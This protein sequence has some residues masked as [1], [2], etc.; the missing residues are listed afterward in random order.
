MFVS[1]VVAD[2]AAQRVAGLRLHAAVGEA[3]GERH[4]SWQVVGA[5]LQTPAAGGFNE[6]KHTE[7]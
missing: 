4:E 1:G 3:D 5:E 6:Q 7:V 2:P